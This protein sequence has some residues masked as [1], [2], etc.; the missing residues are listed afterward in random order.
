MCHHWQVPRK[1]TL[2]LTGVMLVALGFV[3]AL[4]PFGTDAYLPAFPSMAEDLGVSPSRIGLTLSMFTVGMSVGQFFLGALT[5]RIG[6]K[7]VIVS[8][9]LL[10]AVASTVAG[11]AAD[12]GVLIVLCLFMGFSASAGLVGGRAVVA[13]LTRGEAAVR[14]FTILGM[15]VSI[16]PV[17]G[18]MGGAAL[19]AVGGWRAIFFG[20]AIYALAASVFVALVVP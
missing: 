11:F 16:G 4:G 20:L 10:M 13:D 19:L 12:A 5:D 14:P 17:L 9:G 2:A 1:P 7:T 6:R 8:G 18:P 3:G 15:V